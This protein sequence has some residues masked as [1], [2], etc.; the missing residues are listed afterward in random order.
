MIKPTAQQQAILDEL[1]SGVSSVAIIARAGSGKTS[2]I[3]MIVDQEANM[4]RNAEIV[5]CAYN[6]AI[7]DEVKEKLI[8][9][10]HT[11][12]N[13]QATTIHAM[14]FGVLRFFLKDVKVDAKKV[15]KL[16]SNAHPASPEYEGCTR[17]PGQ[18]EKMVR[19]A[20]QSGV[21]F[22]DD[23]HIRD[24]NVWYDLAAHFDINDLESGVDMDEVVTAAQVIYHKSLMIE[25]EID[26][27]DMILF[28]L[29]KN[30]RIKYQKDLLIIDEAQDLSR[31][32]QALARKFLKPG[33]R[34]V[35]VGDDRQ[36]IYGFSGADAEALSNITKVMQAKVF[37]LS[38]SWRCPKKVIEEAQRLV[39]DIQA[40]PNAI[41]G[42]VLRAAELREDIGPGS[43]ILCRN[44]APLIT[45]AYKLIKAGKGAKVEG[46]DIGKGLI[47]LINR[48]KVKTIHMLLSRLD[49]YRD[50][51]MQKAV[52]KG[53]DQK[54][55]GIAD[56]CDTISIVC[57]V[58]LEK[59]KTTVDSVREFIESIFD[60][61][62][63][64]C[65]VL[66]TYHRSK[67]REWPNVYL[68][69]HSFRCPSKMARLPWQKEQEDNLAYVAITRAQERLIYLR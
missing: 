50:R 27:D 9:R 55:E 39:P 52:A 41:D 54:A 32:R 64:G 26:F 22:F 65:I 1:L 17:W 69:E 7:A 31:V 25:S 68:L 38:V 67:G 24:R 16:I 14:G 6:K 12:R 60:D 4:D 40:A 59:G 30:I 34:M 3:L 29:I 5:V 45:E 61:D 49:A 46:R 10:G 53:Q 48:W 8:A 44:T 18:V 2:T 13:V 43:A 23:M 20:K 28:P 21:G 33:G 11:S 51:E 42:E 47:D 36:A 63:K 57:Q 37:P 66:A 19:V 58:C 62:V 56:K 15:S 35:I